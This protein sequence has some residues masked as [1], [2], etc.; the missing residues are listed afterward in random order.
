[1]KPLPKPLQ[2]TVY[3]DVLCSWC[4]LAD[5]RLE[6]LKQEF[7]DLIR[8]RV[9]PYPLRVHDKRPTEKE[10]R[11]L[12]EEV[13]R[14]QQEPEPVA[15]LLTPELWLGGD[16]PRTSIPALAALEA[17]RLQSPAA[18]SHL[19]RAMQKAALEQGVNVTRT[20]VIFE[21]ASRVGLD[22]S[23]FSAA[24]HSDDTRKLILDEHQLAASRGVRGVPTLVIAG[25]WMVC[26]LREVSEYR[27]HI[28][29]CLGKLHAPRAGSSER[30]VH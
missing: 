29:T 4:Y 26:G 2:I 12:T 8:W 10:L 24:Y 5:L 3:Q 11:G 22:M 23:P 21:L 13:R 1:M 14:A 15:K 20:D 16:A 28:L 6:T 17:A 25:R 19:A 27:E 18:R 30:M 7:G 9:R